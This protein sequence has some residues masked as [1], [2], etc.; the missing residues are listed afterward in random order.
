MI[1]LAVRETDEW[2]PYDS[3][4]RSTIEIGLVEA[5]SEAEAL[6]KLEPTPALPYGRKWVVHAPGSF[7]SFT[8]KE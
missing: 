4:T 2:D 6:E 1:F 8:L 3:E 5:N 7:F